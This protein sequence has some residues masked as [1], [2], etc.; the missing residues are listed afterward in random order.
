MRAMNNLAKKLQSFW[1]A[2]ATSS[3]VTSATI[4][5]IAS[6]ASRVLGVM[7]D[8]VLASSFG[9]GDVL[10]AYYAA[11]RLPDLL[12]NLLVVGALSAGF[13]PVFIAY[14]QKQRSEHDHWFLVNQFLTVSVVILGAG[15]ALLAIFA[16]A[17]VPFITPGFH[18]EKLELV[19]ML[20]RIMFLSPILLGASA[21]VGGILQSYRQFVMY[22][23][24]PMLYNL[25]IIF[26]AIYLVPRFGVVGL[27]W[28]VVIGALGHLLLQFFSARR[29][30]WRP[31]LLFEWNHPGL[32]E[33]GK[34]MLP[35][36]LSLSVT[37]LNIFVLTILA[38][39]LESGSLAVF[40]LATNL[41]SVPMSLIGVSYALAA[42]PVLSEHA[43]KNELVAFRKVFSQTVRRI[44]FLI[45]PATVLLLLLRA[46]I[47]RVI[48]GA[49]A[50]GWR[51]TVLTLTVVGF[52]TVS[53]FAQAL[54]PLLIRSFYAH[55]K[56]WPPFVMGVLSDG[57]IVAV[58]LLVGIHY[59]VAGLAAAFSFGTIVEI[60]GLWMLLHWKFGDLG[61][62]AV[63]YGLWRFT[64]AAI[65]MVVIVQSS[66]I[67][68]GALFGTVTAV[69]I[70][71]QG[72]VA[73]GLGLVTYMLVL[74]AMNSEE[75]VEFAG[76]FSRRLGKLPMSQL[77][78]EGLDEGEGI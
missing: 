59:G 48:F 65:S 73:G 28:G 1:Q 61:E 29:L 15:C 4:I 14:R 53:L 54:A 5:A 60:V 45:V 71:L 21:I 25:G 52:L 27:A 49:G 31:R 55:H 75:V 16:P 10:D 36:T 6:L 19:I 33:I 30:G 2:D 3:L 13:I 76:V 64:L 72:A 7:R 44:I 68:A 22:S 34:L 40:T 67:W 38:S 46:Q 23:L 74:Y 78:K 20:S 77:S 51:D 56:T 35:N 11:F 26:G 70:F 12:Y 69:G 47:V 66:K 57:L 58:S 50:F 37:Q 32:K 8:R 43:A 62:R 42:F 9:A 18:G 39:G 17:V 41:V 63:V 24:A